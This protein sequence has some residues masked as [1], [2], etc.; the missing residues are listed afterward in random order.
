M[1]G[2]KASCSLRNLAMT[3][4]SFASASS[5]EDIQQPTPEQQSEHLAE[6]PEAVIQFEL[7]DALFSFTSSLAI[8][9]DEAF[10]KRAFLG[11]QAFTAHCSGVVDLATLC[12]GSEIAVVALSDLRDAMHKRYSQL[13]FNFKHVISSD[14][15]LQ[16]Q[17]WIKTHLNPAHLSPDL[18]TLSSGTS[19]DAISKSFM[20]VM[21]PNLLV[22]GFSCHD[23][24][25]R[26]PANGKVMDLMEWLVEAQRLATDDENADEEIGKAYKTLQGVLEFIFTFRPECIILE[27]VSSIVNG[28]LNELICTW[29]RE[30]GYTVVKELVD[31][32]LWTLPEKQQRIYWFAVRSSLLEPVDQD[33]LEANF[34]QV[35]FSSVVS[36][37]RVLL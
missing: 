30:H 27:N 22:C 32:N 19:W 17:E 26:D 3:P 4:D 1:S 2:Q 33:I 28:D 5:E 15:C 23:V 16:V 37:A 31:S 11:M 13:T 6:Q 14:N 24:F 21:A 20:Q 36:H 7:P 9:M 35:S 34:S 8:H 12:A 25:I 18:T 10:G 29:L